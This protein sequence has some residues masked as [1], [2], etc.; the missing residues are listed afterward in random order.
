MDS[1]D[2]DNS[3]TDDKERRIEEMWMIKV[4]IIVFIGIMIEQGFID[5]IEKESDNK[6]KREKAI[7]I[8][9]LLAIETM[10]IYSGGI[11]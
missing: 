8:V 2:T 11:V 7:V 1:S 5:I 10:I 4:L 9:I 6:K 3:N